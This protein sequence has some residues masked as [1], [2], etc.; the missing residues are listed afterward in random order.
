M[1]VAILGVM[2]AGGASIT[3][4]CNLPE[5]RLQSIVSQAS[6]QIILASASQI[7][8]ASRL[9]TAPV[10]TVDASLMEPI[11][12]RWSSMPYLQYGRQMRSMS[13]S[14]PVVQG[15]QRGQ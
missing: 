15:L 5:Q 3:L 4:D 14:P 9:T 6:P 10:M 2:K 7:E 12:H 8:L 1:P 13:F 11:Y